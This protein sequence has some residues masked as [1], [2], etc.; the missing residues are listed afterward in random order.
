MSLR[1]L[2]S[3]DWQIGAQ[4]GQFEPAEAAY[5]VDA[6]L[7]TV[8]VIAALATEK[9]VDGVLVAGDVFDQQTVGD[10]VIRRLFAALEGFTG[11]WF[12]LPGNHDAALLESV[13][14]RALRL[15]CVPANVHILTRPEPLLLPDHRLALI[16]A[17]LTQRN[18]FDDTTSWFDAT[19]TPEGFFRIGLAHGSVT[20]ILQEG[21]DATNPIAAGRAESARLDYLALGDWHGM[22]R[23]NART[24]YSGTHEQDRFRGN[25]PG[26]VLEVE[27]AEPGTEPVVTPHRVS[28]F[29]WHRWEEAISVTSDIETLRAKINGLSGNDVLRL[30]VKGTASL[31]D[32]EATLMLVDEAR[33]RAR[34]VRADTSALQA[35][36]T[37]EEVAALASYGGYI[38]RVVERLREC[39]NDPA[40]SA[41]ATEALLLLAKYHRETGT[42]A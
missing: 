15:G 23:I 17:P 24:W 12:L 13:W 32:A 27:L 25:E 29:R 20:G 30:I 34:A 16:P 26:H 37:L 38:A 9:R 42:H 18:T 28:R 36:P 11:P 1:L 40:R 2:H 4:F 8:R 22:L 5:L 31:A 33:A 21:A 41:T 3:A 7:E 35:L 10:V 39:Q 14:T 19:E 6:R